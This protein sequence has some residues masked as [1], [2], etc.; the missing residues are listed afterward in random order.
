LVTVGHTEA[1]AT[2]IVRL[3]TDEPLARRLGALAREDML[4]RFSPASVADR[5]LAHYREATA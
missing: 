3:L 1:L 5:Y 2:A 4:L